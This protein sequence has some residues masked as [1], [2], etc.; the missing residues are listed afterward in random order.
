M[1]SSDCPSPPR[2]VPLHVLM[3]GFHEAEFSPSC[4]SVL[5]SLES[6]IV[7]QWAPAFQKGMAQLESGKS[8]DVI[9]LDCREEGWEWD[10]VRQIQQEHQAAVILEIANLSEDE[11]DREKSAEDAV[12]YRIDETMA[13]TALKWAIQQAQERKLFAVE[14]KRL[15]SQLDEAI[16]ASKMADGASTILHNVG[17]VL[18]SV[19]VAARSEERRVGKEC[20]SRWSPYH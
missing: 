19:T 16:N 17:N 9:V 6:A 1:L 12:G 10:H 5:T 18:T 8:Y 2:M 11:R 15:Q 20:R 3:V 7:V 4:R 14:Q 13:P